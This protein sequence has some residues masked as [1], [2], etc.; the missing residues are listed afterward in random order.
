MRVATNFISFGEASV[1]PGLFLLK[2]KKS[3]YLC[4]NLKRM[5]WAEFM[6]V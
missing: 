5:I 1:N 2:F 3:L 4:G 6:L